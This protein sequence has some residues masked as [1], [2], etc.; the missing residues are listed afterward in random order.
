MTTL[1]LIHWIAGLIV[2]AEAL[3][4]LQRT[5]LFAGLSWRFPTLVGAFHVFWPCRW[6]MPRVVTVLKALGWSLLAIGSGAAMVWPL[7]H[8]NGPDIQDVCVL[9]GFALLIVR[10]RLREC[11]LSRHKAFWLR[12]LGIEQEGK[13]S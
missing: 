11:D 5:D 9:S 13:D 8:V 4:K 10:T 2:L 6:S 12:L 7:I 1:Y 3:N